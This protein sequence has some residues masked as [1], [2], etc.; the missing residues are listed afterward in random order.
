MPYSLFYR[1]RPY[2]MISYGVSPYSELARWVMDRRGV[3][4]RE[5]SHIPMLHFLLVQKTDELPGLVV[6][7]RMLANAREVRDYWEAH[8]PCA[9]KL[10][11]GNDPEVET[12]FERFY[13]KTGMAVRR[14][15]YYYM[16]PD[17]AGT[18]KCW[19]R[20]APLWEKVASSLFFPIM[21]ALMSKA[22]E[23]TPSAP[24]ES[25]QEIDD[26]F[27]M[28]EQR[29][30]DGR[31]YLMGDRLTVADIAFA[32]L[33]APVIFPDGYAGPLPTIHELP[34][35]MREQVLRLRETP[36]GQLALRLYR[37]ERGAPFQDGTDAPRGIGAFFG[38]LISVVTG[39][40]RVLRFAFGL[41]RRFR[42]I[43]LLG[44]TAVVSRHADVLDVLT[45][46][47]EFTI[48]E[49][50]EMRMDRAHAPF[51]LGWDRSPR[52]D[53]EAG[54]LRR[55]LGPPDLVTIR[56]IV[57]REA[58]RLIESA[59]KEGR[60]DVVSGLTRV[61]PTRVVSEFFGTPGPNEQTMMR[62]LR[63]LFYDV[64]LNRSDASDVRQTAAVYADQLRDYLAALIAKRKSELA[65][66]DGNRDDMLTRLLRMQSHA[67]DCL[68]DDGVR[69]NI[70]G[71]I[72]G[73]VDTTSAA[74]AQAIDQILDRPR[75]LALVAQAS[76]AG[77]VEAVSQYIFEALRFNPQAPGMLRFC[78]NGAAVGQGTARETKIPAGTSMVLGTLS[79]MF[80]PDAFKD[81]E[82]FRID[83]DSPVYLHF[84][85]GMHTCYGRPINMV[86]IPEIAMALFRL[87]GLRRASGSAGRIVYD[88]PFPD[89]L[90]VEFDPVK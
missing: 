51:I 60:L 46:D 27:R 36:A 80:D 18:L 82:S 12:L 70:S 34:S 48:S 24:Q 5:E 49:I 23:L 63:V 15:A 43:L 74:L 40:P 17:R 73:A 86:Q 61:V 76:K 90:I 11:P 10:N 62:W 68:D 55:A 50:N 8:S 13:S 19:H 65:A 54:I 78:R 44:K 21:R 33:T 16:L 85:H 31:R 29:L 69:R 64:F 79:A 26:C 52:Y 7:E 88:G 89:R 57:A 67:T 38:R 59:G 58:K 47:Q 81:P 41:L 32:A 25:M 1:H 87:D 53:R 42:P 45:R 71:I 20:G 3:E 6:P 66:G 22:I 72:V 77:D 2:R 39:N 84:G 9:E 56:S 83:R 37:E 4:Y 75:E 35:A 30:Q 28:I 14:F